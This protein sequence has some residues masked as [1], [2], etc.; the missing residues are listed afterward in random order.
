MCVC[1]DGWVTRGDSCDKAM[2]DEAD[3]CI[4]KHTC[5]STLTC[6]CTHLLVHLSSCFRPKFHIASPRY[7]HGP[8]PV[9][10]QSQ[11]RGTQ[12]DICFVSFFC[13]LSR[14]V[15]FCISLCISWRGHMTNTGTSFKYLPQ[16]GRS[17]T[18]I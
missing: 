8:S 14:S 17:D 18:E 11:F 1:G 4:H 9:T 15:P 10:P 16:T 6:V 7:Q 13:L 5:K 3:N 12:F 2:S